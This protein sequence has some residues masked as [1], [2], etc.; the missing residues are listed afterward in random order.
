MVCGRALHLALKQP[1]TDYNE[2]PSKFSLGAKEYVRGTASSRTRQLPR[3]PTK[4]AAEGEDDDNHA[5]DRKANK[6]RKKGLSE[7]LGLQQVRQEQRD[8]TLA[9]IDQVLDSLND[10]TNAFTGGSQ[11]PTVSNGHNATAAQAKDTMHS[12]RNFARPYRGVKDLMAM[13]DE[14]VDEFNK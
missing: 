11:Q 1:L 9:Q 12:M 14:V 2:V 5:A 10:N 4:V 3:I 8:Y 6:Y 13:V 7:P